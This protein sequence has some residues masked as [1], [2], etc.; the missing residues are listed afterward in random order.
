MSLF[1]LSLAEVWVKA[2]GQSVMA[3]HNTG[4]LGKLSQLPCC[5]VTQIMKQVSDCISESIFCHTRC[6]AWNSPWQSGRITEAVSWKSPQYMIKCSIKK[7]MYLPSAFNHTTR[8]YEHTRLCTSRW[9]PGLA[10]N[11]VQTLCVLFQVLSL[12]HDLQVCQELLHSTVRSLRRL[13]CWTTVVEKEGS[14]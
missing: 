7:V 2:Y 4:F 10:Q 14:F 1:S 12:K 13:L 6:L 5:C 9:I 8:W 11:F 3:F